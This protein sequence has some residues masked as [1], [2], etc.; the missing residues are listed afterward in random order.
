MSVSR[1]A[2]IAAAAEECCL[3]R[4]R[5]EMAL[6]ERDQAVRRL[7]DLLQMNERDSRLLVIG[8]TVFDLGRLGE[9]C[10][11]KIMRADLTLPF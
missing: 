5:I 11:C 1:A 6:H 2:E 10:T 8:D 7:A 4:Q 3:A 9:V